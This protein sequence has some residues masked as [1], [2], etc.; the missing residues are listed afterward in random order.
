MCM[1]IRKFNDS[2]ANCY[3]I[4]EENNA[5]IVDPGLK[6]ITPLMIFIS[7]HQLNIKGI[8][9]THA[10]FDHFFS[11]NKLINIL[12]VPVYIHQLDAKLLKDPILNLSNFMAKE[13]IIFNQD[14]EYLE[15]EEIINLIYNHPI[16]IIHTP[17]H[18][19]G[20]CCFYFI[21]DNVILTGD[22]L[23]LHNIGRYDLPTS[24][25]NKMIY[26]LKKILSLDDNIKVYP[27]HGENTNI[28]DER[29]YFD[30]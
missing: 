10:H 26:S 25:P 15:D 9:L 22:S 12:K 16:K 4:F 27:G 29:Q 1:E 30:L 6:D 18:S 11:L 13:D 3:L 24:E 23:F 5:I 17:Y 2:F 28:G 7:D 20:S 19:K 8:L 14:V 21:K